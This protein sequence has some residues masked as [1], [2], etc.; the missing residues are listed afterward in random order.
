MMDPKGILDCQVH[1]EMLVYQEQLEAK[2]SK[3]KLSM[4]PKVKLEM[5]HLMVFLECLVREERLV[6]RVKRDILV[7]DVQSLVLQGNQAEEGIQDHQ[8]RYFMTILCVLLFR[9]IF[10]SDTVESKSLYTVT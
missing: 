2:E 3:V 10:S 6:T 9:Y 1:Q 8:V 5:M 7:E 4:D